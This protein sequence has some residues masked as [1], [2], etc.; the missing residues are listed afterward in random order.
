MIH[1]EADKSKQLLLMSFSE[2]VGADEMKN[3]LEQ[4]RSSL[5]DMQPGFR[6]L[7]DLTSLE[8][9]DSSCADYIEQIMDLCSAKGVHSIVRVVPDS[10]KDIGFNIMSLFHHGTDV[11]TMT[12]ES[13]VDAIQSF[14]VS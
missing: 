2:R 4:T 10:K 12:H 14:S 13:L 7:T 3:C 6:L 9:M 11:R 1:V 8:F 5:V